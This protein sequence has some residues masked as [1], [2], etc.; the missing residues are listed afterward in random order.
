[1][2][3]LEVA[4]LYTEYVGW[5]KDASDTSARYLGL[6]KGRGGFAE[7]WGGAGQTEGM[8]GNASANWAHACEPFRNRIQKDGPDIGTALR[9]GVNG[10]YQAARRAPGRHQAER[11]GLDR[12]YGNVFVAA[13]LHQNDFSFAA[14]AQDFGRHL[15]GV[16]VLQFCGHYD[17]VRRAVAAEPDGLRSGFRAC[18][19]L[20]A[21]HLADQPGQCVPAHLV[22]LDQQYFSRC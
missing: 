8:R 10:V 13:T 21:S 1:M 4:G 16:T 20:K 12:P 11:S 5:S 3:Q 17:D 22:W 7:S 2:A 15:Y 6:Q 19:D 18:S 9:Y 14:Y